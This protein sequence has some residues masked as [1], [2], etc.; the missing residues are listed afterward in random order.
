[1]HVPYS[2]SKLFRGRR[3][4]AYN[5]HQWRTWNASQLSPPYEGDYENY[6][7]D[8][9]NH[10]GDCENYEGDYANYE[11]D[12]GAQHALFLI[13]KV[14]ACSGRRVIFYDQARSSLKILLVTTTST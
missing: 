12:G 3:R 14:L 10:E 2:E 11:G 4:L 1:M 7:G 5:T 6:E 13:S 8:D 9:E